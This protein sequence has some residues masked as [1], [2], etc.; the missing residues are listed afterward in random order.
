MRAQAHGMQSTPLGRWD[1]I[2][3]DSGVEGARVID[4][5]IQEIADPEKR[6]EATDRRDRRHVLFRQSD[7]LACRGRIV[8][9]APS[10]C[11]LKHM[12]SGA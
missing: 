5:H 10:L 2:G 1:I 9:L 3:H 7:P 8:S 6:N 11:S 12:P 4:P